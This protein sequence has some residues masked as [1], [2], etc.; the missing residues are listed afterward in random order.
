MPLMSSTSR[1]LSLHGV[2]LVLAVPLFFLW[3]QSPD[4]SIAG[5]QLFGVLAAATVYGFVGI[6]ARPTSI[7]DGAQKIGVTSRSLQFVL[8]AVACV[9]I[10]IPFLDSESQTGSLL[11]L[12]ALIVSTI[13]Y[14]LALK[15]ALFWRE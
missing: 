6:M 11:G 5:A 2:G 14:V 8:L 3:L 13:F 9:M 1:V 15:G 12:S 4:G 7:Y 10:S